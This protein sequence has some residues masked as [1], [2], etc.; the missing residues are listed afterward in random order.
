MDYLASEIFMIR[1]AAFGYNTETA[2]SNA[3]Q[4]IQP[5][6]LK[7]QVLE[8]AIREFDDFVAQLQSQQIEVTV[9]PDSKEPVKPDAIFPNNWLVTMPGGEVYIFP[10]QAENRRIEKRASII[11]FLQQNYQ[12]NLVTDY[13]HFE[14]EHTFL[15]G[16]GSI[17][18]DHTNKIMYACL[19]SRTDKNLLIE[20]ANHKK[21]K[22]V[23][24]LSTLQ[25]GTP[26]YHTNV[27]MNLGEKYAVIC[28]E[29]IRDEDEKK[30][31]QHILN[32]TN[33]R[34]IDISIS[35]MNAFAGNM[36]QVKNKTGKKFTI[37]SQSAFNCLNEEQKSLIIQDST[38]LPVPIPTIETIGGGSVRCMM[39]EIFLEKRNG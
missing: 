13:T 29:T 31:F 34:I 3:F 32:A 8:N 1:P 6:M 38:L 39:A 7:Q 17:I 21:Y 2:G 16:T 23:Y 37:L 22:P 25:N 35:Q 19:S 26:I 5:G 4:Q 36:L 14:K 28:L 15:E 18:M 24:F 20:F 12:V 33:K 11:Q 27:M 10:M 30:A 9:F